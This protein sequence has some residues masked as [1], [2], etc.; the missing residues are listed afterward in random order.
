MGGGTDLRPRW[1]RLRKAGA[2][3]PVEVTAT[4]ALY[5][6]TPVPGAAEPIVLDVPVAESDTGAAKKVGY[7]AL[8]TFVGPAT[9]AL[10]QAF[11]SFE[12]RGVTDLIIDL[13]YDGGGQL[14]VAATFIDLLSAGQQGS[15][16][17]LRHNLQRAQAEDFDW[18]SFTEAS[19]LA[20]AR[21]AFILKQGSASASELLPFAL[22]AVKGADVAVVGEASYGKPA[23]QYGFP[24]P[25]CQDL[26]YLL[27]FQLSNQFGVPAEYFDG[28]PD[29]AW[30]GASCTAADDPA[31]PMGDPL[32]A[33]TAA[34]RGWIADRSCAGGP[35][36]PVTGVAARRAR[37]LVDPW[38]P[39]GPEP[40]LAQRH[41][42]G[43]L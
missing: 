15:K 17:G 42:P 38:A 23:G 7:L 32:E 25:G 6:I 2:A 8:R 9:A 11:A 4:I 34:A 31:H 5:L 19:A 41:V 28:L 40:T 13:R 27:S 21:V 10:R 29:A 36:M 26:L 35:I 30:A 12:S 39:L 1:F 16:F 18:P 43:L 3:A 14:D 20:P 22:V 33:M 24:I 37:T